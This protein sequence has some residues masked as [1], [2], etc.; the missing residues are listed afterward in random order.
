MSEFSRTLVLA[1]KLAMA[2]AGTGF[3]AGAVVVGSA[4]EKI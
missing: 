3:A 1:P 2:V 4:L